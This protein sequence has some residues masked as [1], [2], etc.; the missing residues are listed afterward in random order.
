MKKLL[1][2]FISLFC[3]LNITSCKRDRI[4]HTDNNYIYVWKYTIKGDSALYKYH[5]PIFHSTIIT[6]KY[7]ERYSY[8]VGVP[9]KGGHIQ[10]GNRYYIYYCING[11]EIE[12]RDSY[13]YDKVNKG[14]KIIVCE[15]FYPYYKR[16]IVKIYN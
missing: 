2:I 10:Y 7:K 15:E 14:T 5:Q 3:L 9:D 16:K 13:V 11:E 4:D 8:F 1:F 12:E 6:N